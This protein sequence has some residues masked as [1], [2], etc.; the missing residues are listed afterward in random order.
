MLAS[1]NLCESFNNSFGAPA[2]PR[3]WS[4]EAR[5]MRTS[6]S[7]SMPDAASK[8]G[9]RAQPPSTTTR[10]PSIVRLDSAMGVDSTI[11]RTPAV[12]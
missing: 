6:C 10:T 11:R 9:A 12:V 5:E 8:R 1:N 2:R 4:A 7:R 3:R